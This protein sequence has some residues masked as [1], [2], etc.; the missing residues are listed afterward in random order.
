[1]VFENS[2]D[3]PHVAEIGVYNEPEYYRVG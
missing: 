2:R 3:T 1:L